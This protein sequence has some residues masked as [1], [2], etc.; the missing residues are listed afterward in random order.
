MDMQ[1][2]KDLIIAIQIA[3]P[4]VALFRIKYIFSMH[5]DEED[6]GLKKRKVRNVAIALVLI[7]IGLSLGNIV[8][9]YYQ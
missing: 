3:A 7:E 4:L 2:I 9:G 8:K 5:M 1:N 6:N